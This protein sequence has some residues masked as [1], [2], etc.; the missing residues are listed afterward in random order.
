MCTMTEHC[1]DCSRDECLPSD[2]PGAQAAAP[3]RGIF[4]VPKVL[5][6]LRGGSM[7]SAGLVFAGAPPEA[8]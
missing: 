8:L 6:Q 1:A 2:A 4:S 7:R 5:A 3:L